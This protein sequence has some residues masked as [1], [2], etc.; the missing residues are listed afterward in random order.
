MGSALRY[1]T[2]ANFGDPEDR[3][4]T[5]RAPMTSTELR[6][7]YDN[8]ELVWKG[9]HVFGP[10]AIFGGMKDK[11]NEDKTKTKGATG[12]RLTGAAGDGGSYSRPDLVALDSELRELL[13]ATIE[14]CSNLPW[15][16]ASEL[17]GERAAKSLTMSTSRI[18]V[19]AMM[20]GKAPA[21]ESPLA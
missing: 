12:R 19:K 17:E 10:T 8:M 14:A 15:A 21:F 6:K 2:I 7:T 18:G 5:F 4:F 16:E 20:R 3:V 1:R 11:K 9:R 13:A